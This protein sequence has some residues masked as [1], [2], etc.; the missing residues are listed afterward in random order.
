MKYTKYNFILFKK[1]NTVFE[2]NEEENNNNNDNSNNEIEEN[3]E[4]KLKDG[5]IKLEILGDTSHLFVPEEDFVKKEAILMYDNTI[6][7]VDDAVKAKE[8]TAETTSNSTQLK[9]KNTSTNPHPDCLLMNLTAEK[10]EINHHINN[11]VQMVNGSYL[12]RMLSE[13]DTERCFLV[14][15]FVP[16]CPYSTRLAP[17][18]NALPKAFK[19]LDIM[20]FDISNSI[21]YRE[22]KTSN[23]YF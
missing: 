7:I 20:A 5:P 22:K 13:A 14:L 4:T 2:C 19:N 21:G 3:V 9:R 11:Q 16:W 17:I 6:K 18:Y 23:K 12:T 10:E 8:E 15:F 1:K